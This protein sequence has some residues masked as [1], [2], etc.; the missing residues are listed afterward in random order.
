MTYDLSKFDP[1]TVDLSKYT[2]IVIIK[3]YSCTRGSLKA[4]L[5]RGLNDDWR[6]EFSS[7]ISTSEALICKLCGSLHKVEQTYEHSGC[8]ELYLPTELV[9]NFILEHKHD[10]YDTIVFE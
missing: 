9:P 7:S 1:T 8:K 6:A 3:T 10:G 2:K 4:T 5:K